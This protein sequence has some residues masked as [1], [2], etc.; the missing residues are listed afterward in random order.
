MFF[1]AALIGSAF[2]ILVALTLGRIDI[3]YA[4]RS[5]VVWSI[6]G[7]LAG[8][9]I[10]LFTESWWPPV[11]GPFILSPACAIIASLIAVQ[12]TKEAGT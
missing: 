10:F 8:I 1:P 12:L 11:I 9:G 4:K 6:A 2:G 7:S 3:L 5:P